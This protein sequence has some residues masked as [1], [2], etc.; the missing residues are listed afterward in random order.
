MLLDLF[1]V[2]VALLWFNVW[3]GLLVLVI[4][5]CLLCLVN[6][7]VYLLFNVVRVYRFVVYLVCIL[8][9]CCYR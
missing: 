2:G 1:W 7:V 9:F 8:L 5:R 3:T 6:S 4:R